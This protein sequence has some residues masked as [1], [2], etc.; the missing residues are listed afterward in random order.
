M[1]TL[2][3]IPLSTTLMPARKVIT[4]MVVVLSTTDIDDSHN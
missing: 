4:I 2:D 1:S 3:E